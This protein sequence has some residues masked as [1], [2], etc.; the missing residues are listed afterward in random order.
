MSNNRRVF[1]TGMG[2]I[3]PLGL[4]TE[5]TWAGVTQGKSGIDF[6]TAFDTEGF[7]TKFAAEVKGFD[8]EAYLDRKEAR[9]MDRFAQFAAVAAQEACRQAQLDPKEVDPYKVGVIIGSGIGGIITLSQQFEILNERG[10][11]RVSPFLIPMMLADMASAQVSMVTGAMGANYCTVSSCSS[12]ADALGQGW[13]M[14]VR[15]QEEIVLAGGS[16]APIYPVAV[17]GFNA[18]RA[19]SRFNEDPQK[20]SRPFDLQRDGFVMG[21]GSA[22]LVL[23]SGESV[24]R[25]GVTPLAELRGYA[26]TSDAHHITEP[27]PTG[28]NAARAMKMALN[29]AGIDPAEVDYLNAHGTS[30]PLNDRSETKAIKLALG[31]DAFRIFIS[32]SKSMTGHLLGSGGALEAAICVMT[33]RRGMVPPTINLNEPDPECDLDYTPNHVR[34]STINVAM[35]NSFGFGGHNSVLVLANPEL[36]D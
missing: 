36:R 12:G 21:E 25:R 1:V 7:D 17:A 26:A 27:G 3:S 13:E 16:E 14:I 35:S 34:E 19:L 9:R 22:V 5:S 4:D 28:E 11:K 6:I 20:A 10:P 30:T 18:L 2:V 15:G 23:E 33:L 31:E 32:S 29:V 24:Q 8:P